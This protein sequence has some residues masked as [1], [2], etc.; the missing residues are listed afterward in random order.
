VT[1]PRSQKTTPQSVLAGALE[2]EVGRLAI[3]R[4]RAWQVMGASTLVASIAIFALTHLAAG[5]V[6]ICVGV[7]CVAWFAVV[8]RLQRRLALRPVLGVGTMM[9]EMLMPWGFYGVIA[10]S[11]GAPMASTQWGCAY[12]YCG[13]LILVILR[14]QPAYVIAVGV[15]SSL[16]F[17]LISWLAGVT[18]LPDPVEPVVVRSAFI[19]LAAGVVAIVTRGV[20]SAFGGVVSTVRAQDLFGKYRLERQLAEGGMGVVWLATYCPEGGFAR[21]AAVKLV[22]AHLA[23]DAAFVDS[24]RREAE[25]GARLV[26]SHIVQTFD[27]GK[28]GERYFLAME[29][30]EGV[31]LRDVIKRARALPQDVATAIARAMLAGLA[32]A[33]GEARDADGKIMRVIHRDLAPSNIL[34]AKSG[35]VKISDFGIA[36]ALGE[37]KSKETATVVGHFD[38]MAPEQADAAPLDERAD[39]FCAGILLWEMLTGRPLFKRPSE[40]ATLRAV[41]FDPVPAPSTIDPALAPWDALLAR[42][43]D[44]NKAARFPSALAMSDAIREVGGDGSEDVIARFVASLPAAA[45]SETPALDAHSAVTTDV[46]TAAATIAETKRDKR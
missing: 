26:H 7:A 18:D 16:E 21:P 38:H 28:T 39:L 1:T 37:A 32:F 41:M 43:L 24:F 11:G 6:G 12:V 35:T 44:R 15:V 14:L 3:L 2:I 23:K 31:T 46:N 27:F 34:I 45:T 40:A 9:F 22:H 25:L 30:V 36:W 17:A 13:V 33:H 5:A 20:K 10:F 19:L 4:A 8:S 42:A 29:F